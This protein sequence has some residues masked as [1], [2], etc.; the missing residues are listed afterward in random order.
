MLSGWVTF[1]IILAG[2]LVPGGRLAVSWV[3]CVAVVD[4]GI[5]AV[6]MVALLHLD[7]K[8][9]MR[10][11]PMQREEAENDQQGIKHL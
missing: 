8:Q 10:E 6:V 5:P 4:T 7:Y 2:G 9:H 1:A 3:M 11:T